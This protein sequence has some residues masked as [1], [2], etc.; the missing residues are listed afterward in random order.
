LRALEPFVPT[1]NQDVA[2][3]LWLNGQDDSAIA[4]LKESSLG[5]NKI[6]LATIYAAMGRYSEA[7]DV[8]QEITAGLNQP[9]PEMVAEAARLLR[10]APAKAASPQSLPRLGTLAFVYLY[11][12]AP[13]RTLESYEQWS[14]AGYFNAPSLYQFWHSS[15]AAVRK[16]ERFK[17]FARKFGFVEYWRAKGWPEFCHPTTGDDFECS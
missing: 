16:T 15:Y 9:P 6:I 17:A 4:M 2:E 10:T 12:G 8:I 13:N 5:G 14:E 1:F 3:I 7:A 11:V